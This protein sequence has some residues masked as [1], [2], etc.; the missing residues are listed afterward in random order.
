MQKTK[1]ILKLVASVIALISSISFINMGMQNFFAISSD[2]AT[3]DVVLVNITSGVCNLITGCAILYFIIDMI[4]NISN[5]KPSYTKTPLYLIAIYSACQLIIT[6]ITMIVYSLWGNG[7]IWFTIVVCISLLIISIISIIKNEIK[8]ASILGLI[9][10]T[11]LIAFLIIEYNLANY[12]ILTL[13]IASVL[14]II[15]YIF[16]LFDNSNN[17]TE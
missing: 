10:T 17:I 4:V 6:V 12:S 9:V 8:I 14:A 7:D 2:L 13:I 3:S 15:C 1:N 16:N 5:M 11:L